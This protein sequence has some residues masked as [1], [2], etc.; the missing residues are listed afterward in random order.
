M[1]AITQ[2][3]SRPS[4]HHKPR[5]RT[6]RITSPPACGQLQVPLACPM[7]F[8]L[9]LCLPA[10]LPYIVRKHHRQDSLRWGGNGHPLI[11]IAP[12]QGKGRGSPSLSK[13]SCSQHLRRRRYKPERKPGIAFSAPDNLCL[14]PSLMNHHL[15]NGDP[16][17][18]DPL[19]VAHKGCTP[20]PAIHL[21]STEPKPQLHFD[22]LCLGLNFQ[23]ASSPPLPLTLPHTIPTGGILFS[24]AEGAITAVVS[25]ARER[26]C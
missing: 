14:P 21:F 19:H 25:R 12:G 23:E 20:C 9:S 18:I 11:G 15:V 2:V 22:E 26:R 13:A 24:S 3:P 16:P 1:R 6:L 7:R 17:G 10:C 5:S 8:N 4:T